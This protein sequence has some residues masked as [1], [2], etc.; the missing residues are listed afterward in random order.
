MEAPVLNNKVVSG[1][2]RYH[3]AAEIPSGKNKMIF[4]S[5]MLVRGSLD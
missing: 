4:G 2:Y 1:T 3:G 5:L